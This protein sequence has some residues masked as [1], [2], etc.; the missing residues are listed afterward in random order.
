MTD[1]PP[2]SAAPETTVKAEPGKEW[3]L[4]TAALSV[5]VSPDGKRLFA[6]CLDGGI[7]E[8]NAASGESRQVLKHGNYASGVRALSNAGCLV[9]SGYDGTVRLWAIKG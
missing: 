7:Y 8:V 6:A 4:P 5:D 1:A 2:K 3:K 9:S